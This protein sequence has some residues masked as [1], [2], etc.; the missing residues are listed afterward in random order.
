MNLASS[1]TAAAT[2]WSAGPR[3]MLQYA[4]LHL[5]GYALS[6]DDIKANPKLSEMVLVKN[7]RLS[8]QPVTEAEWTEVCRMGGLR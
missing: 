8:V 3:G 2:A 6:L 7:S 1:G 5:F 4:L